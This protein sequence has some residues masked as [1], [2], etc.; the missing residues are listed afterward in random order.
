MHFA[1]ARIWSMSGSPSWGADDELG[2]SS[3]EMDATPFPPS[4]PAPPQAVTSVHSPAST[5]SRNRVPIVDLLSSDGSSSTS[6]A[7]RA[8]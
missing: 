1:Y 8:R 3:S 4:S 7:I 6:R 2:V 5:A